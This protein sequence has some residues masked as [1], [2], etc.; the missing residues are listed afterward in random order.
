MVEPLLRFPVLVDD[1]APL[2][3]R[4]LCRAKF[5]SGTVDKHSYLRGYGERRRFDGGALPR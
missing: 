4:G 3:G 5:S 1:A 2:Y